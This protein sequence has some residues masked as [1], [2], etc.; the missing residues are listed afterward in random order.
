MSD[1]ET[2]ARRQEAQFEAM[3]AQEGRKSP[4]RMKKTS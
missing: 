4:P 1:E 2:A 3:I